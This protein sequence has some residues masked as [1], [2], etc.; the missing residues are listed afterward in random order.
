ME[1]SFE[2]EQERNNFKLLREYIAGLNLKENPEYN[3]QYLIQVLHK[4]QNLFGYL[5]EVVLKCISCRMKLHYAE[6]WGV[7]SFY[8]Y[9]TTEKRGDFVLSLCLGTACYVK[10][11]N[12]VLNALKED[13]GI[14]VGE[15]T[16]DGKFTLEI[17]RCVGA[18]G[19]APVLLINGK[20]YGSV[21]VVKARKIV[22][23]YK[24]IQNQKK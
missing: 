1:T 23:E 17:L 4:A 3:R 16:A 6:I 7:V 22:K 18:C 9:F 21:D 24:N 8:S 11:A 19:I 10:G 20:A 5:P 14:G 2:I 15:T 13:L 12:E